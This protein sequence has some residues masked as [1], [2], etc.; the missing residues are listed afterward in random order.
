MSSPHPAALRT[1]AL[2]LVSEGHSAKEV[3]RQLGIPP[4]TVYRWQR[5]RASQSNLT[6]ARTRIEELE[7]EVLLCRRVIDVMR[8]VMPPKDV[9]K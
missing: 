8:Q 4:Q 5:S 7:G 6:Q 3:A 2:E 1:R 9:T